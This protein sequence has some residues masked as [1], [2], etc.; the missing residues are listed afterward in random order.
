MMSSVLYFWWTTGN[1]W[2][3]F[4]PAII[5]LVLLTR[6]HE[7]IEEGWRLYGYVVDWVKWIKAWQVRGGQSRLTK[8]VSLFLGFAFFLLVIP[9]AAVGIR[10]LATILVFL[11]HP[12]SY[13]LSAIQAIPWNWWKIAWATDLHHPPEIVPGIETSPRYVDKRYIFSSHLEH[14]F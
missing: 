3:I 5:A 7:S 11:N 1:Y 4:G 2:L 13:P 12:L 6:T 14:T 9:V 10:I 8:E